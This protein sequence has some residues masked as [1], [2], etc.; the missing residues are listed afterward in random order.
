MYIPRLLLEREKK[1]KKKKK[2]KNTGVHITVQ[3]TKQ[4]RN[5]NSK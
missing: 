2:K 4:T 1:K 3:G 5:R